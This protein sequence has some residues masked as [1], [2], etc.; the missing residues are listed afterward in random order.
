MINASLW[1]N[2]CLAALG[3]ALW[4]VL[5]CAGSRAALRKEPLLPEVRQILGDGER[6]L[7]LMKPL[8]EHSFD[9]YHH[10]NDIYKERKEI[11]RS[12]VRGLL[13]PLKCTTGVIQGHFIL[14]KTL[15]L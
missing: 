3:E 2:C 10:S 11:R 12:I 8:T 1:H 9:V 4:R 14:E 13:L 6:F 15:P 7:N 5:P